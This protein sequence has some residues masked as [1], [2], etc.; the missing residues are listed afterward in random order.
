MAVNSVLQDIAA[1][2]KA[3]EDSPYLFIVKVQLLYRGS[4]DE[5]A[6][7]EQPNFSFTSEPQ[8]SNSCIY[9]GLRT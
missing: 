8:N 6:A 1:V 4:E 7:A 5:D 9:P 3:W 2:A